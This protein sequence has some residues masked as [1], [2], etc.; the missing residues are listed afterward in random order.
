MQ[1]LVHDLAGEGFSID[2]VG[3]SQLPVD[4]CICGD[5]AVVAVTWER[6]DDPVHR[7]FVVTEPCCFEH[8]RDEL[9]WQR[10]LGHEVRLQVRGFDLKSP[11]D[12]QTIRELIPFFLDP[13]T[14]NVLMQRS[15]AFFGVTLDDLALLVV[16]GAA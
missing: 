13:R 6:T 10:K 4:R 11:L 8:A 3:I 9:V 15:A 5:V 12:Q 7:G 16:G 2:Q 14:S 1:E